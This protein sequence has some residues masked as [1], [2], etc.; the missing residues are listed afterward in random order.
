MS[1]PNPLECVGKK[2]E[3]EIAE[4]VRQKYH[5]DRNA[6]GFII[7]TVSD[8]GT[9]LG[10]MLLACKMM[11]KCQVTYVPAYVIRLAGQYAKGV[12][13]NWAQYLCD[14]FNQCS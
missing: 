1:G 6:W 4:F 11:R 13:F 2:Y 8:Q 9:E 3:A 12:C 14:E 10:T 7:K 5:V